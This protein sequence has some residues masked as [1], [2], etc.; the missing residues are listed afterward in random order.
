MELCNFKRYG[1][2]VLVVVSLSLLG[3]SSNKEEEILPT[4]QELTFFKTSGPFTPQVDYEKLAE[5]R[6]YT[7]LY[8]VV[9]GDVLQLQIPLALQIVTAEVTPASGQTQ[10]VGSRVS[11]EGTINLPIIGKIQVAGKTL[12]EIEQQVIDAYYPEYAVYP[13]AILVSIAEYRTDTVTITGAVVNPGVYELRHDQMSLVA[14]LMTAGGITQNGATLIRVRRGDSIATE[15]AAFNNEAFRENINLNLAIEELS[16]NEYSLTAA[17]LDQSFEV[18]NSSVDSE[19]NEEI[20]NELKSLIEVLEADSQ[21]TK[22]SEVTPIPVSKPEPILSPK[23]VSKPGYETIILP[24]KEFNIP[25]ADIPLYDGDRVEVERM[26]PRGFVVMGLV[27]KPGFFSYPAGVQYNLLQALG[28]AGGVDD[29]ADPRY[30]RVYRQTE[31]GQIIDATFKVRGLESVAASNIE[32]KPGDI[33]DVEQTLRTRT[34]VFLQSVF[35][36]TMGV[37]YNPW[38]D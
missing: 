30:V 18:E 32:I 36:I 10:P 16:N 26:D 31:D 34:N 6:I 15:P 5:V 29:N 33:V 9:P 7:G 24:V 4:A 14:L 23:L 17:E 8:R 35:R 19:S 12:S 22:S 1:Y 25:F 11:R 38:D 28:Y 2:V 21:N 37:Y 3:C 13:P 20:I 27:K